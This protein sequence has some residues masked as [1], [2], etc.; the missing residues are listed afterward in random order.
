MSDEEYDMM[1]SDEGS[2]GGKSGADSDEGSQPDPEAELENKYF[3]AKGNEINVFF[4]FVSSSNP[5]SNF[6][7]RGI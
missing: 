3:E 2:G 6:A 1:Y 5:N 7:C 4:F